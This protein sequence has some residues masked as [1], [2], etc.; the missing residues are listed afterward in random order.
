MNLDSEFNCSTAH[1]TDGAASPLKRT[2]QIN[3]KSLYCGSA[4]M[5]HASGEGQR[6]Y[7]D[8]DLCLC[9]KQSPSFFF[10]WPEFLKVLQNRDK[11]SSLR[12]NP[13][14]CC[15]LGHVCK[16]YFQILA[17]RGIHPIVF[18]LPL[19][20]SWPHLWEIRWN[21]AGAMTALKW[22]LLTSGCG[23]NSDDRPHMPLSS[24]TRSQRQMHK[25]Y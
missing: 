23:C 24:F 13:S 3:K 10:S 21:A 25:V 11:Q 1:S 7:F 6:W 22:N 9:P 15:H 19:Q 18:V 4:P 16:Y 17:K 14:S 2:K 8:R 20:T 12:T 5:S